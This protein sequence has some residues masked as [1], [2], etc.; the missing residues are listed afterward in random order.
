MSE[1]GTKAN[2]Q[3]KILEGTVKS[4]FLAKGFCIVKYKDWYKKPEKYGEELL[5]EDAPYESIYNHKGKME[6]LIISK[7]YDQRFRIEC[8]W[9]QVGGSVDEKYPYLYLNCIEKLEESL[10]I[11]IIDGKGARQGA[12][13][14][15]KKVSENKLYTNDKNNHKEVKVMSLAEFMVWA[16]KIFN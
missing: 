4:V 6:F 13:D 7:K 10:A 3:G 8:K 1:Q 9:Q 12:V 5:I 14:W 16:N 2:K 15:L 11:I